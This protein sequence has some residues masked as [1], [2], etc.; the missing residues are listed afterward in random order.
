MT[1][2]PILSKMRASAKP[3]YIEP[4]IKMDGVSFSLTFVL[5]FN[6]KAEFVK[7]AKTKFFLEKN[8]TVRKELLSAVYVAAKN[9][10]NGDN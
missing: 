4:S 9:L 1:Q 5:S 10:Q 3:P 6:S 7:D 2:L 8:L